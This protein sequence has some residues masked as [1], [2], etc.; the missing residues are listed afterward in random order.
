MNE[1][2]LIVIKA[3]DGSSLVGFRVNAESFTEA[4]NKGLKVLEKAADP[5]RGHIS[6]IVRDSDG[7]EVSM[8]I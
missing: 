3:N 8:E 1:A 5:D 2:Y 7:R 4:T 6:K